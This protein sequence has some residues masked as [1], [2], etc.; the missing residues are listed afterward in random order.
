MKTKF[1][2]INPPQIDLFAQ[3]VF[4]GN[5]HEIPENLLRLSSMI[6]KL[7]PSIEVHILDLCQFSFFGLN[8][9]H[10]KKKIAKILENYSQYD[11]YGV[12]ISSIGAYITSLFCAQICAEI[13]SDAVILGGGYGT[14]TH[15]QLFTDV[16]L[17]HYL[18]LYESEYELCDLL[19]TS[20]KQTAHTRVIT[21]K[22]VVDLSKLP[23]IDFSSYL[24]LNKKLKYEVNISASRGCIY[25]CAFCIKDKRTKWTFSPPS[26]VIQELK[27]GELYFGKNFS[28]FHLHEPFF[29]F[30][31]IWRQKMLKQIKIANLGTLYFATRFDVLTEYDINLLAEMKD[32]IGVAISLES[33]SPTIL[34]IMKKTTNPTKYL[35]KFITVDE[36]LNRMNIPYSVNVIIGHP[37]ETLETLKE[38][39]HFYDDVFLNS[40]HSGPNFLP[41]GIY[42]NT[43]LTVNEKFYSNTYGMKIYYPKNHFFNSIPYY[44]N[45]VDP[46]FSFSYFDAIDFA[47]PRITDIYRKKSKISS[48]FRSQYRFR[49]SSY[50]KIFLRKQIPLISRNIYSRTQKFWNENFKVPD[51][52]IY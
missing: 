35:K 25:S 17:F 44:F 34:S 27:A 45:H 42:P 47:I 21:G 49:L 16:N 28:R 29:G 10:T 46:S 23:P 43:D 2:F 1:L 15:T 40:D 11:Y 4:N 9:S 36:Q 30:D 39:F 22:D 18:F 32:R 38:S 14:K 52:F 31:K 6:K 26:R 33:A 50:P 20:P 7:L 37:G 51:I 19:K 13:N 48:F 8:Y 24:I 5:A 3:K 12:T 41:L